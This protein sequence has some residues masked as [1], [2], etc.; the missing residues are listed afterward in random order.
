MT[1]TL[2]P[3][4]TPKRDWIQST[5]TWL[6]HNRYLTV[7]V[8]VA[9]FIACQSWVPGCASTGTSPVTG[10]QLSA[11]ALLVERE[12]ELSRVR[13]EFQQKQAKTQASLARLKAEYEG[14][15][16]GVNAATGTS[17]QETEAALKA[18]DSKYI[19]AAEEIERKDSVVNSL[20]SLIS[21]TGLANEV[22][23]G[24]LALGL[25]GTVFGLG[26]GADNRRKNA[27]I[28]SL[29]GQ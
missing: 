12:A 5:L 25:I 21:Q 4:V 26:A 6:G 2:P 17:A 27:V 23:G 7:G 16:A 3:T 28:A 1:D 24:A 14:A 11:E 15:I 20:Y 22:P 10:E 13:L 8:A 29:K 19:L 18:L 9:V